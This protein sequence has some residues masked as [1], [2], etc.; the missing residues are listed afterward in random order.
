MDGE[1]NKRVVPSDL[2]RAGE[3]R[4]FITWRAA[5]AGVGGGYLSGF[6][7]AAEAVLTDILLSSGEGDLEIEA[8]H[9]GGVFRVEITHPEIKS[10]RM[11]DLEELLEKFLD[12]HEI[13]PTRAV[14]IKRLDPASRAKPGGF[15]GAG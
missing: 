8:T 1:T 2:A 12:G 6:A 5:V 9:S 3:A 10:R 13:S 15:P 14:L 11:A 4:T 7:T